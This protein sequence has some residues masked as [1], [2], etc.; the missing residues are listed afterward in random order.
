M[1]EIT[2]RKTDLAPV[3]VRLIGGLGNQLFQYATARAV[4][5]RNKSDLVLD[6]RAYS[7]DVTLPGSADKVRRSYDLG[8]FA[9]VAHPDGA[10]QLPPPRSSRLAYALWRYFR[11]PPQFVRE[12]G[13]GFNQS[14]IRL[15]ANVYLHG[16][17]QSERYFAEFADTIRRELRIITPPSAENARWLEDIRASNAVSLHVRRGDYVLGAKASQ[18]HGT[19]SPDYYR[20]ALAHIRRYTDADP[21]VYVFS[22]DPDWARANILLDAKC[23]VI[24][25][26]NGETAYEDMRLMAACAHH[27]IANSSLSWWGAWLDPKPDKCVVA[28]RRWTANPKT[29]NPDILPRAWQA[30]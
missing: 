4:A 26:N 22:D 9:I 29:F 14:V 8:N 30:L 16:Y 17:F 25:H 23:R 10:D 5:L 19:C 12:R 7:A 3:Y 18:T 24:G 11:R 2:N 13:L 15:G 20:R 6:T 1:D 27:I 21:V 28:P